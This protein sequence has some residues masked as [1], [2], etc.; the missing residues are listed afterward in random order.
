MSAG[1]HTPGPWLVY[2]GDKT[3]CSEIYGQD[4]TPI[5]DVNTHA[6]PDGTHADALLIAAT[7]ELLAAAQEVLPLLMNLVF[8]LATQ[9]EPTPE[10]VQGLIRRV[11]AESPAGKLRDA[12]AKATG[13]SA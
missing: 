7:P 5:A 11:E 2:L 12:I 3:C 1:K 6:L 10:Q 4:G 13:A 9:E 8:F